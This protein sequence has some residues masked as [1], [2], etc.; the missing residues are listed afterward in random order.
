[1][2]TV[3]IIFLAIGAGVYAS[4]FGFIIWTAYLTR[5]DARAGGDE[6]ARGIA[7]K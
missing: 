2:P 5:G 4:L 3:D 7:A 1:M 6:K